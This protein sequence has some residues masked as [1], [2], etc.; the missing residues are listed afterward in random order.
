[1]KKGILAFTIILAVSVLSSCGIDSIPYAENGDNEYSDHFSASSRYSPVIPDYTLSEDD[2]SSAFSIVDTQYIETGEK[3]TFE[4]MWEFTL[5]KCYTG[6]EIHPRNADG[7]Y[8]YYSDEPDEV[9]CYIYGTLTNISTDTI[10]IEDYIDVEVIFDEKYNYSGFVTF[11]EAD[12]SG[13]W[14]Y[15]KPLQTL[16]LLIYVSMPSSVDNSNKTV[17]FKLICNNESDFNIDLEDAKAIYSTS[18]I[19]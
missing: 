11:E 12:G 2:V 15:I 1:M 4:D 18:F 6:E 7:I 17:E 14:A 19:L 3:I 8:S 13:F 16:N 9:Y 10:D 5:D